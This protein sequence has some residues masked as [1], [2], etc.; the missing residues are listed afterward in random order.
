MDIVPGGMNLVGIFN[1]AS[2]RQLGSGPPQFVQSGIC[3]REKVLLDLRWSVFRASDVR[4][5][6]EI[7]KRII[8]RTTLIS[9]CQR[10][11]TRDLQL[12]FCFL[13]I[14]FRGLHAGSLRSSH[15]LSR[16]GQPHCFLSI[17]RSIEYSY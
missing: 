3:S 2:I 8:Y 9:R 1:P 5:Q 17:H 13:D 16:G 7:L 11:K 10:R 12:R 14:L 4:G 6:F 15:R